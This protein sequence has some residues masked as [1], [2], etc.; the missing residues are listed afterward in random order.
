[1]WA[2][3]VVIGAPASE[4]DAGLGERGKQ[5][6]VQQFIPQPAVDG[7]DGPAPS[8][9]AIYWRWMDE[10]GNRSNSPWKSRQLGWIFRS[11]YFKS[12]QLMAKAKWP[13]GN[14]SG[15]VRSCRSSLLARAL[16]SRH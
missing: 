14:A 11:R 5:R 3:I 12:M 13:V 1:M 2:C 9:P 8:A 10:P 16:S 4:R 15:E 6:L 7:E